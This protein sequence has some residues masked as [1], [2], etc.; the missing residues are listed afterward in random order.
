MYRITGRSLI[1]IEAKYA[2]RAMNVIKP[3]TTWVY[4]ANLIYQVE[5]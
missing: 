3:V 2:H 4:G 5:L 1:G